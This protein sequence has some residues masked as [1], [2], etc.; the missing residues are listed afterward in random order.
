MKRIEAVVRPE[1]VDEVRR[2]LQSVGCS[3]LMIS[4]IMGHGKQK[5]VVQQWRGEKFKVE[6]LPKVKVETIVRNEDLAKIIKVICETARTGD[7][8][9]GKIFVSPVENVIR[10]RTGE[11]GEIAI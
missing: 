4:E 7:I 10:I 6:L 3:G 2:A 9:D 11:E 1:K 5:G 8:G